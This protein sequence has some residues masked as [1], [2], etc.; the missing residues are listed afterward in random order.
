MTQLQFKLGLCFDTLHGYNGRHI[1]FF[2]D[3]VVVAAAI[4]SNG[5]MLALFY[6]G[7]R[8]CTHFIQAP[9]S[10]CILSG[11]NDS[12]WI[13]TKGPVLGKHSF[14]ANAGVQDT[15]RIVSLQT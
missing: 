5:Y 15:A 12:I 1:F 8:N 9:H 6:L 4:V 14:Y 2:F 7:F 13:S 10:S 3:V 11:S